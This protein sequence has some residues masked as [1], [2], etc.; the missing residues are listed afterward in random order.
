MKRLAIVAAALA[1]S[2]APAHANQS[3]TNVR[4]FHHTVDVLSEVSNEQYVC[5]TIDVP[6]YTE[7]EANPGD[8]LVG[9]IIGGLLGGTA[10]D[11]DKGAAIGAFTGGVIAAE[12]GK[13]KIIGYRQEEVCNPQQVTTQTTRPV[14]SHSTIRFHMNGK[15]YVLRFER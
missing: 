14:Y 11:S 15:R 4:V 9:A 7:G 13:K 12:K 8:F 5:E 6:V 1:T 3:V 2:C 10:T